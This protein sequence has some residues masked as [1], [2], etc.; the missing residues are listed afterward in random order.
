VAVHAHDLKVQFP[1]QGV[2]GVSDEYFQALALILS[3]LCSVNTH[4]IISGF[5]LSNNSLMYIN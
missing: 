2:G 4:H 3:H 1:V 5:F